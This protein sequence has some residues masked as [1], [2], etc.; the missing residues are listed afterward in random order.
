MILNT[1]KVVPPYSSGFAEG[2]R[3]TGDQHDI[4]SHIPCQN[5]RFPGSVNPNTTTNNNNTQQH[6]DSDLSIEVGRNN[7]Y[8]ASSSTINNTSYIKIF[9]S[10]N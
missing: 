5:Q 3:C 7:S 1:N 4:Y 9:P 8:D 10:S 6:H 2:K